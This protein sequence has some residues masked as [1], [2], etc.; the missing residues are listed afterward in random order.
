MSF[1]IPVEKLRETPS[2]VAFF[3]P[4]PNYPFH[5][6]L[7]PKRSY[8]SLMDLPSQ[9]EDFIHDLFE[10]TQS[11]VREFGLEKTGYRLIA[12]GGTYQEAPILHF[13]LISELPAQ[14]NT[15]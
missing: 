5:V 7:V 4:S 8:R 13:H 10:Q 15:I 11:L 2:M 6:L 1:I 3:H 14:S 12:N 9:D